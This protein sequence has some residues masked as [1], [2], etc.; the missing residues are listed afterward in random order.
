MANNGLD[1]ALLYY[2]DGL[3]QLLDRSA[4]SSSS[5][6]AED[7]TAGNDCESATTALMDSL[8]DA[9]AWERKEQPA[10]NSDEDHAD[11]D[12]TDQ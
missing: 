2:K 1:G 6:S 11:D 12:E 10:E 7:G 5:A 3:R 9:R 4:I 8:K